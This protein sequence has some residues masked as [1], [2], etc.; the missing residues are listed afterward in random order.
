MLYNSTGVFSFFHWKKKEQKI[1]GEKIANHMAG[2]RTH[3]FIFQSL[4][5]SPNQAT[6]YPNPLLL[7]RGFPFNLYFK[8]DP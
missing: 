6:Q 5:D 8:N 3:I 7:P 1:L 4:F 2:S